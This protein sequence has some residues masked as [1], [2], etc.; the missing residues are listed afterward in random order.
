[1]K[2]KENTMQNWSQNKKARWKWSLCR[3]G[4]TQYLTRLS[5]KTCNQEN[6]KGY[7]TIDQPILKGQFEDKENK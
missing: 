4:E 2:H 3:G 5:I 7:V 1:M 6:G